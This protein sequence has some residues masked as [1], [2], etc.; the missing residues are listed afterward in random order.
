M[1]TGVFISLI[2]CLCLPFRASGQLPLKPAVNIRFEGNTHYDDGV[3]MNLVKSRFE[4]R[5]NQDLVEEDCRRIREYYQEGGYLGAFCSSETGSPGKDGSTMITFRIIEGD[6][7]Y[8]G[9]IYFTGNR[10]LK[11]AFLRRLVRIREGDPF[12]KKLILDTQ[13]RLMQTNLFLDV[14]LEKGQLEDETSEI[15]VTIHVEEKKRFFTDFGT[16]YDSEDSWQNFITWGNRNLDGYA[17]QV[18]LNGIY[19][20][21]YDRD[22]YY[23]KGEVS[24]QYYDFVFLWPRVSQT[25]ELLYRNDKPKSV[26]Y[27]Y[28][29]IEAA[30]GLRYEISSSCALYTQ[31]VYDR[32]NVFAINFIEHDK[33]FRKLLGDDLSSGIRFG[34]NR[35]SRNDYADPTQGTMIALNLFHKPG[36]IGRIQEYTQAG[37]QFSFYTFIPGRLVMANRTSLS[38][39]FRTDTRETLPSYLRLFLGG[40][41]SLRGFGQNRVGPKNPDGSSQGGHFLLLNN[42]EIRYYLSYRFNFV[43]LFDTGNL[44]LDAGMIKLATLKNS[45]GAGFRFRSRFGLFRLDYA[46]PV[47]QGF[48]GRF[49]F[50]FG[51]AF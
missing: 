41:G 24:L 14:S 28:Q 50:G 11:T 17:R 15:S 10:A 29:K 7:Y 33:T 44:W 47:A 49:H 30:L 40:S 34:F 4:T 46:V 31:F 51:Q 1:R 25:L 38:A 5:V 12:S 23:K 37:G 21:D 22:L 45:T 42:F 13:T 48:P 27:G 43:L 16:G 32:I 3:L 18:R 8:F 6:L 26:N 9:A 39:Q 36:F 20:V 35:D 2:L 19:A